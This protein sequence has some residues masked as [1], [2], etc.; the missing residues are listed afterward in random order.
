MNS[1]LSTSTIVYILLAAVVGGAV[2]GAGTYL[3]ATDYL[4]PVTTQTG[5]PVDPR[6]VN[7]IEEESATID[8]VQKVSPSVVS[9]IAKKPQRLSRAVQI[10]FGGFGGVFV[11]PE[12]PVEPEPGE[13]QLIQ[14]GGG[15]GFFVSEDGLIATNRHV[16]ADEQATYFVVT[17][18]GVEMR[19]TVIAKDPFYDA[20]VIKVEGSG[21]PAVTFADS[22]QISIGQTVIAIGNALAEFQ[23]TVTK[24]VVSGINRRISAGNGF[25]TEVIEEAIQTD[26]AINPGNSG[27]PLINLLG[28]VVGV[29]TAVNQSAQGLGFAIPSNIVK[30]VVDD[31]RTHGRI[32]RPWIGV[33]YVLLNPQI[34]A[35]EKLAVEQGAYVVSGD[36][37]SSAVIPYSPAAKAGVREGDVILRINSKELDDTYSLAEAVRSSRVGDQLLLDIQRGGQRLTLSVTLEEYVE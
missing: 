1:S 15:T 27:G 12:V 37:G 11:I 30:R 24:G 7:L 16:V 26:A 9:V 5:E 6:I 20:A 31:V 28:E 32:V 3:A 13:E 22:D 29:N 25:Q 17:S 10:P 33:R 18:D 8:V 4:Y 23:N 2:G 21:F 19:A 34:A 14:V 36:D 35:Q